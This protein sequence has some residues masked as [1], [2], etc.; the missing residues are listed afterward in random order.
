MNR[1]IAA[2][3][4]GLF[5]VAIAGTFFITRHFIKNNEAIREANNAIQSTERT[6]EIM[7]ERIKW[8]EKEAQ[9]FIRSNES[10][11]REIM[12]AGKITNATD[13]ASAI[14]IYRDL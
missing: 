6:N 9:V 7:V 12:G 5:L 11:D 2:C 10:M 1:Y 13:L 4:G 8:R 14:R 3:I